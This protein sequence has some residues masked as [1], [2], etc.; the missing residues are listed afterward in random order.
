MRRA[1]YEEIGPLDEAYN[2][3]QFED[4]DYCYRA[5][6]RGWRVLYEPSVEM[7]HFENVTTAG[8]DDIPFKRQTIKN[9]LLFKRRW[10]E[11]IQRDAT[12]PDEAA[13]WLPLPRKNVEEVNALPMRKH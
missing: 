7:Y 4:I 3:V 9:G 8:S 6:Q 2:P 13:R 11:Q 12:L 5:R 1:V 10:W